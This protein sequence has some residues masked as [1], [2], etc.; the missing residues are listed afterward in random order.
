MTTAHAEPP[1][2]QWPLNK[3]L[4]LLGI[5]RTNAG[6]MVKAGQMQVRRIGRRVYVSD[7]ELRRLL[8]DPPGP[9]APAGR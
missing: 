7:R 3:A 1:P 2:R 5:S 6:R 9:E 8:G 4:E